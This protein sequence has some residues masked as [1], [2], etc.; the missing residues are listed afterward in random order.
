MLYE[1]I[2]KLRD[3]LSLEKACI[4]L[5]QAFFAKIFPKLR[6]KF[7]RN[8]TKIPETQKYENLKKSQFP[9]TF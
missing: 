5:I 3:Y 6:P 9:Q 2:N 4:M 8:S 1:I 7:R